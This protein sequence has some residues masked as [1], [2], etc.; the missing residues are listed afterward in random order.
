M[1]ESVSDKDTITLTG[2]DVALV[3]TDDAVQVVSPSLKGSDK[4]PGHV[5]FVIALAYLMLNDEEWAGDV[6]RRANGS[7]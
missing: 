2:D 7:A 3:L 5:T 1:N 4:A 6:V